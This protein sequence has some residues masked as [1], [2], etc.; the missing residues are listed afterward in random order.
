MGPNLKDFPIGIPC[1]REE[2]YDALRAPCEDAKK[3]PST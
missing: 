3:L 2:G 1:C